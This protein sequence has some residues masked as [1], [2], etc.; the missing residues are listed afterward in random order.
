MTCCLEELLSLSEL[1]MVGRHPRR[2]QNCDGVTPSPGACSLFPTHSIPWSNTYFTLTPHPPNTYALRR[3]DMHRKLTKG[4]VQRATGY[5]INPQG[6][7]GQHSACTTSKEKSPSS[8]CACVCVCACLSLCVCV[9]ARVCKWGWDTHT[10]FVL[11]AKILD[12]R[13]RHLLGYLT[14]FYAVLSVFDEFGRFYSV[15]VFF[16]RPLRLWAASTPISANLGRL[17]ITQGCVNVFGVRKTW[18]ATKLLSL[19]PLR[20]L[21]SVGFAAACCHTIFVGVGWMQACLLLPPNLQK[22]AMKHWSGKK[23]TVN[24]SSLLAMERS[25]SSSQV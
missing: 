21:K 20:A 13:F 12:S 7:Y 4:G 10:H 9:C 16:V 14:N 22:E 23:F 2:L 25:S 3:R 15:C 24:A 5:S 18:A 1:S 19:A 11:K 6:V 17:S 8:V